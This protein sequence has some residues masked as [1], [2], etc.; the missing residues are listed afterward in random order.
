MGTLVPDA[1][2]FRPSLPTTLILFPDAL[3]RPME[4]EVFNLLGPDPQSSGVAGRFRPMNDLRLADEDSIFL[5]VF[6]DDAHSGWNLLP[7]S[8]IAEGELDFVVSPTF[9]KFLLAAHAPPWPD[10]FTVGISRFYRSADFSRHTVDFRPDPWVARTEADELHDNLFALRPLLPMNELLVPVRPEDKSVEYQRIWAA[11]AE[12][13]IRW[14]FSEPMTASKE[15][16]WRF[17]EAAATQPLTEA[18]FQSCFGMNFSDARDSLSDFL[19]V[20]VG[21]ELSGPTLQ[22]SA[23]P[24][25]KVQTATR[26]EIRRILGEWARRSRQ[27][28]TNSNPEVLALYTGRARAL[29]EGAYSD[30]D[31]DPGLLASVALFRIETGSMAAGRTILEDNPAACSA[32]PLAQLELARLLLDD[33]LRSPAGPQERL[34]SHQ[35]DGVMGQIAL[36]VNDA[37]PM[38]AVYLLMTRLIENLGRDPN[39]QE[40]LILRRG[41]TMFP[42]DSQLLIRCAS[43]ILRAGDAVEARKLVDLGLR[44]CTD[45]EAR[46]KL[47]QLQALSQLHLAAPQE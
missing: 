41:A 27:V 38:E 31:R 29:L 2:L 24:A 19:P 15:R 33:A 17:A 14:A 47:M 16:L 8:R 22:D 3:K 42:R 20:A 5:F 12:L 9:L 35:A 7:S 1:F 23:M 37:R 25:I 10:W 28:L 46:K 30:G 43:L 32:R 18:L 36:A 26:D 21:E 11:Q 44:Q 13:F 45:S 40:Q 6:L 34:S 4:H 39:T